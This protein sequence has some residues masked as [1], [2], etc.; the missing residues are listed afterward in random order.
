MPWTFSLGRAFSGQLDGAGL[1]FGVM[2][3]VWDEAPGNRAWAG[4][5]EPALDFTAGTLCLSNIAH[6]CSGLFSLL[7]SE[8]IRDQPSSPCHLPQTVRGS[9]IL[10]N[11][12]KKVWWHQS[13]LFL[14]LLCNISSMCL[15]SLDIKDT[16]QGHSISESFALKYV[17]QQVHQEWAA[18]KM[19]G[20]EKIIWHIVPSFNEFKK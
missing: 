20:C 6:Q 5:V 4:L 14:C 19:S 11:C 18:P 12:W 1:S 17:G 9:Q 15:F 10:T 13:Y 7:D 2:V 3:L 16:I 8:Q